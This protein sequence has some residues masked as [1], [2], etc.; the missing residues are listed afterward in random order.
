MSRRLARLRAFGVRI[1]IDDFGTGYS[2]LAYLRTLPVDVLKIDRGFVSRIEERQDRALFR[3]V[4][5]LARSMYLQP[6]AEG[7]ETTGQASVLREL[8]CGLAQGFLFARPMPADALPA[9]LTARAPA[10]S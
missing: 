6:V 9:V 10:S 5:E 3:A 7:V 4:V 1:A 8:D 2:S